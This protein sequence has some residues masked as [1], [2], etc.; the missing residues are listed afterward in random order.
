M[1]SSRCGGVIEA[2]HPRQN[3]IARPDYYD[4]LKP[5]AAN[6]DRIIIVSA[7]VPVLSSIL[8]IVI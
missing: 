2:I 1:N 5:I 3:E 4:G 8:S 6:I 7:V